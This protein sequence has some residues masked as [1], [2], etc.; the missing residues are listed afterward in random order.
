MTAIRKGVTHYK[1][2]TFSAENAKFQCVW[3]R[4]VN[5]PLWYGYDFILV[6]F[7][8]ASHL[9]GH[10]SNLNSHH[11]FN[12]IK[13]YILKLNNKYLTILISL[14]YIIFTEKLFFHEFHN[15]DIASK[16]F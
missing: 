13:L 12:S 4:N 14:M 9:S 2:N 3:F 5:I 6:S 15:L 8:Y 1:W 7:M 10:R 11:S 16:I